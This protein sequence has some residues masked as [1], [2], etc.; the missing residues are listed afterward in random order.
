MRQLLK[1]ETFPKSSISWEQT[2]SARTWRMGRSFFWIIRRSLS[3]NMQDH[4]QLGL[5][6]IGQDTSKSHQMRY[7][8]L[9]FRYTVAMYLQANDSVT[10]KN[11]TVPD[12]RLNFDLK[13]FV[14]GTKGELTLVGATFFNVGA[15]NSTANDTSVHN[16]TISSILAGATPTASEGAGNN[17]SSSDEGSVGKLDIFA[18][19]GWSA[20]TSLFGAAVLLWDDR[21]SGQ[22]IRMVC[23]RPLDNQARVSSE[24]RFPFFWTTFH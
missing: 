13:K 2:S 12:D 22:P 17:D 20:L 10:I 23:P 24:L 16:T 21:T 8:L 19:I 5:N 11:G 9:S 14:K 3:W 4:D 7:L 6:H 18:S 15:G 1:T